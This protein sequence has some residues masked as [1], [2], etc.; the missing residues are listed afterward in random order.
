MKLSAPTGAIYGWARQYGQAFHRRLLSALVAL[1]SVTASSN[2]AAGFLEP[3][4]EV[5]RDCTSPGETSGELLASKSKTS[6]L[7]LTIVTPSDEYVDA[8]L[9]KE[10]GKRG[11]IA[12]RSINRNAPKLKN[13]T[14]VRFSGEVYVRFAS[15]L[16]E[17]LGGGRDWIYYDVAL[18]E[19]SYLLDVQAF[20]VRPRSICGEALQ[21]AKN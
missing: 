12:H 20:G 18:G 2:A 9:L 17:V 13:Q 21:Y 6:E 1:T 14:Q 7:L 11:M 4:M 3:H 16:E 10:H 8:L 15:T 19:S 5:I